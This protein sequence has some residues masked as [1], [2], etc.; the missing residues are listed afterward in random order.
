MSSAG[1]H[2]RTA[3]LYDSHAAA[4][5]APTGP[6]RG[7]VDALQTFSQEEALSGSASMRSAD[8]TGLTQ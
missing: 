6:A 3:S 2:D 7:S 4:M 5:R 8:G 1:E